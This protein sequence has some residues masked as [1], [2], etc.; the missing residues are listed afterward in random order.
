MEVLG[1]FVNSMCVVCPTFS[2]G[3][4]GYEKDLIIVVYAA[5]ATTKETSADNQNSITYTTHLSPRRL[6]LLL[7]NFG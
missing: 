7:L 5:A 6:C 1:F 4:V 2:R 3:R